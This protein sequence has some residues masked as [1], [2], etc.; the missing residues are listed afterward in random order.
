M[1]QTEEEIVKKAFQKL[2]ERGAA[3]ESMLT[4]STVTDR[5][6]DEFEKQFDI[7]LPAL[8]RAYLKGYCYDFSVMC[9]PV[10]LDGVEHSGPESE[11]GLCWIEL[12]SLP[13]QEPLKNLYAGMESF[14]RIC[15]DRNLVNLKLDCIKNFL[16]IG[17]WD[18]PLCIDLSQTD[19][20][21]DIPATWQICRFDET[22]FD[23]KDA[24]YIDDRGVVTGER[25]FPDFQTLL[26]IYFG[27]KYDKAYE[28]QLKASGEEKPDYSFYIQRR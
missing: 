26:E 27:G 12:V 9:A 18:G 2:V 3:R 6:L 4:P 7:R 19:V 1:V 17:E 10:P 14:R 23:W 22:V 5:D 24:G 28:R 8:F 16:P 11:K 21:V 25:K 20:Q 13:S 15:T